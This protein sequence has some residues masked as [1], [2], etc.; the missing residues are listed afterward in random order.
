MGTRLTWLPSAT[1]R[2][3]APATEVRP[4]ATRQGESV[5][6]FPESSRPRPSDAPSSPRVFLNG[7]AH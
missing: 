4:A 7:G 2:S 1:T 5:S 3:V 6:D